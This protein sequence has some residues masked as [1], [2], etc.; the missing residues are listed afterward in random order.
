MNA[1][2]ARLDAILA[3]GRLW[4]G[5][6]RERVPGTLSSGWPALD[7]ACGGGWPQG[8]LSEILSARAQGL[9]LLLPA[10]ARLSRGERWLAWIAPPHIPYAPG[11]EARGICLQRL[12]VARELDARA[13]LWT[14]EQAL[15][16]GACAMVL[17]WPEGV[18]KVQ[19][20]RLQLAAE[21]GDSI[22][23]LF[24][25]LRDAR[26]RSP[27]ALRLRVTP[28]GPSPEGAPAGLDIEILKRRGG[29]GGRHCHIR[30]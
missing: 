20:R 13:R 15:R 4:R 29:R 21:Q 8:A 2:E 16:S 22:G 28:P 18:D 9:S 19:L 23:V 1:P 11:L 10:L 30:L 24:R 12:L 26:Q 14:A 7:Q 3:S 27:A 17:L 5:H 25:P 6:G